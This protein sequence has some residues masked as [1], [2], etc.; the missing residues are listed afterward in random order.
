MWRWRQTNQTLILLV[1]L[2]PD[3]A[4][5]GGMGHLPV[6]RTLLL[7]CHSLWNLDIDKIGEKTLLAGPH[8]VK[9]IGCDV[10]FSPT[11]WGNGKRMGKGMT[12][13]GPG[14]IPVL[15]PSLADIWFSSVPHLG[16]Y[17]PHL[18]GQQPKRACQR[19]GVGRVWEVRPSWL[20]RCKAYRVLIWP[21][22]T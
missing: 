14:S 10:P 18:R 5:G 12:K 20:T 1:P 22:E 16:C 4:G 13:Q 2:Q 9:S 19:K 17:I 11:K 3:K 8:Q 21:V 7:A 15:R 6:F